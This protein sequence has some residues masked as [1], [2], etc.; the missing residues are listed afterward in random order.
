MVSAL[1]DVSAVMQAA[2]SARVGAELSSLELEQPAVASRAT[3]PS[4]TR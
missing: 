2:M 1:L 3:A 4:A